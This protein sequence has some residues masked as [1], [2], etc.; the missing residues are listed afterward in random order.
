MRVRVGFGLAIVGSILCALAAGRAPSPMWGLVGFTAGFALGALR[1]HALIPAVSVGGLVAA[2]SLGAER[3]HLHRQLLLLA[4][5]A[6]LAVWGLHSWLWAGARTDAR[7]GSILARVESGRLLFRV[8]LAVVLLGALAYSIR[9]RDFGAGLMALGGLTLACI[10]TVDVL[11][12]HALTSWLREGKS[13]ESN[14]PPVRGRQVDLGLGDERWLVDHAADHPYRAGPRASVVLL[15]R[16]RDVVARV[17]MISAV[18]TPVLVGLALLVAV[19]PAR[20]RY[21]GCP[22][23]LVAPA[24]PEPAVRVEKSADGPSRLGWYP[25]PRPILGDITGDGTEDII[26]LRWDWDREGAALSIAA[27]DGKTF[28]R[29]WQTPSI[30]AKW[31]SRS[32]RLERAQDMLFLTDSEANL[33][34]HEI[35]TGKQVS[36]AAIDAFDD[37]CAAPDGEPRIWIQPADRDHVNDTGM[38]ISATARRE[39]VPRPEWC[40]VTWRREHCPGADGS[41]CRPEHYPSWIDQRIDVTSVRE[42]SDAGF[43]LG[44]SRQDK[45]RTDAIPTAFV[46]YDLKTTK[47]RFATTLAFTDEPAHAE[48]DLT[49][50]VF[51][52]KLFAYYQL[53]RGDWLVGARDLKTG[54]RLWH[55]TPPRAEHGTHF[56]SITASKERVYVRINTR[57]EV[58]DAANGDSLG[59]VW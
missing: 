18:R 3:L 52:G 23:P 13:V 10:W 38:Q 42:L 26:G 8:A 29:I 40:K 33:F 9:V 48:P 25:Q 41:A 22:G 53:R 55:R 21:S 54:E 17:A 24:A 34:V 45:H 51:G 46:G 31:Y 37:L 50:E 7:S 56:G 59:V 30:P 49:T 35:G 12:L 36:W 11:Q 16:L 57:L 6:G 27:T 14:A 58:L 44:F 2:I 43:A 19:L 28:A 15:G 1:P 32:I 5:P 4:I 20:P 47:E 39:T